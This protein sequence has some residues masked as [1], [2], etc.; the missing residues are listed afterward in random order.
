MNASCPCT[1]ITITLDDEVIKNPQFGHCHCNNCKISSGTAFATNVFVTNPSHVTVQDTQNVLKYWQRTSESGNEIRRWFCGQCG[2]LI[3]IEMFSK[4]DVEG[5]EVRAVIVPMGKFL[6]KMVDGN[7]EG[8][9]KKPV[10]ECFTAKRCPW[11][12]GVDGVPQFEEM[13]KSQ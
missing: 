12:E 6:A 5:K 8:M 7:W 3:K 2:N 13:P 10:M 1:A 4:G 11:L 9:K